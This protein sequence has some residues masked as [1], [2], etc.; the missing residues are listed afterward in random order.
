LTGLIRFG[1][2]EV[3]PKSGTLRKHGVRIRLQEQP[4]Q[5][6][7]ALLEKP[8]E[9]ITREDLQRRVWAD[10]TF[11]DVDHNLNIAINKIRQALGDSPETPRFVETLPRRGYR[12]IAPVEGPAAPPAET[13]PPAAPAKARSPKWIPVALAALA[14]VALAGGVAAW[15]LAPG[16]PPALERRRLTNDTLLK[17]APVLSDGS[18]L[19]FTTRMPTNRQIFQVPISGGEATRLP[20]VL[21]TGIPVLFDITPDGQ[22]LLIGAFPSEASVEAEVWTIRLADGSSRRVA[23]LLARQARY[24]PDGKRIAFTTGGIRAPGSLW[25]ASSDGS[26]PRRLLERKDLEI[27]VPC[28]SPDAARIAFGQRNRAT[29]QANAWEIGDD[30]T[31]LHRLVP[32]WRPNHGAGG[33]TPDGRLLLISAGQFW[34]A[35]QR[36]FF[37]F[38]QPPPLQLSASEPGFVIPLQLRDN[39][40]FY[41]VGTTL[42]GQ[43]QRFD[44]RSRNWEPHLG[45]ISAESVEYSRDGQSLVYVT[46]PE[47]ELWVRR[48]DGSRPIQVTKPPMR[49]WLPRWSP[50]GRVVG[51]MGKS[52]PDEPFR[53]YLVDSAGGAPRL[54][55]AKCGPQG[56]FTWSPD[57]KKIVFSAPVAQFYTEEQYLRILDLGTGEVTKF[58]GS[59]GLHSPHWSPDGSALAAVVWSRKGE[60]GIASAHQPLTLYHFAEGEWKELPNPGPGNPYWPVWSHDGKWI[61]YHDTVRGA[62]VRC[63]V[64]ENRHEEMLPLKRE[65]MTGLIGSWFSLTPDD[66]PMILRRRDIQQIYALDWKSR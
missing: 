24:S 42:L 64:R 65:E 31:G 9:V 6:L 15:L 5:V 60:S 34:I 17:L 61:W 16:A 35:Q 62:I 57:G 27:V 41:A 54:A 47:G 48:A 44:A 39:Q 45:G 10:A 22:E 18:R 21:P 13:V 1:V 58:P 40:T 11:G 25:L 30:G 32:D 49:A 8:G 7:L 51:F 19:Y 63:L 3:E 2:F 4:F 53:T 52:T 20:V 26:N 29:Q 38:K 37:Q 56:D 12:F 36:R 14:V 66:E 33:W 28:W 46:Y 59:E 23:N 43:L 55:C 50:D